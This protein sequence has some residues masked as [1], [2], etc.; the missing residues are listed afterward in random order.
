[1]NI[2]NKTQTT[3]AKINCVLKDSSCDAPLPK[4]L[5]LAILA[6]N[7]GSSSIVVSE[8]PHTKNDSIFTH[9]GSLYFPINFRFGL[10]KIKKVFLRLVMGLS[11]KV[12]PF[13]LS[14]F[15]L[16]RCGILK[17]SSYFP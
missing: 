17:E 15:F 8:C 11:E 10:L 14:D 5:I 3:H 6:S 2:H 9:K 4:I 16:M 7:A 12:W 1:M 13:R